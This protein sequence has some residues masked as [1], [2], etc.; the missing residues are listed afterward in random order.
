MTET[1]SRNTALAARDLAHVWHPCTQM[2]EHAAQLPLIPIVRGD[3]AW[4]VD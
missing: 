1:N 3:G 2:R 4:L